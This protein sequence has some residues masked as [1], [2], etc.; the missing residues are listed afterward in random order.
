MDENLIYDVGMNTGEDTAYYLHRGFRVIAIEANPELC[1]DA[2]ARFAREI[3]EGRLTV[4]NVGIAEEAG[5]AEFWICDGNTVF[6]SFDRR[7]AS[8]DSLP[9]RSITVATQPFDSVLSRFG[10]PYYI[11]TDIEGADILC[12]EGLRKSGD[13]PMYISCELGD[14]SAVVRI[15]EDLK[16]SKYKLI[17][18]Y[19]FLPVETS[20]SPASW[21]RFNYEFWDQV[22]TDGSFGARALRKGLR[23]VRGESI[24]YGLRDITMC[25]RG[26]KFPFGSSGPFG[27]STAGPWRSSEE[28][29]EIYFGME[30]LKKRGTKSPFWNDREYSFWV[31]LHARR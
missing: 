12:L 30:E 19:H 21:R 9:H 16:F 24:V 2:S 17:S 11:K 7:I 18:Q 15:L 8:R 6:S 22:A 13:L 10:V 4:L 29:Q 28:V 5:S 27:E 25:E 20:V 1:R 14:L 23:L 26:W 31:D 3:Q